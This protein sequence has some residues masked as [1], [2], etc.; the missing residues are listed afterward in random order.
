[1][2]LQEE[3]EVQNHCGVHGR[4]ATRLAEI[5]ISTDVELELIKDGQH[6]DCRSI[7]E[8]LALALTRGIHVEVRVKGQEAEVALTAVRRL[9]RGENKDA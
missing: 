6:V 4:V 5:A 8:V 3:M 2:I 9:L 7:L 1:M